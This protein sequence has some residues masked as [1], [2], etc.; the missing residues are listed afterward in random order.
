MRQLLD[1]DGA[2]KI[3]TR[4]Q[5]FSATPSRLHY[6]EEVII[7][8]SQFERVREFRAYLEP[9]DP[10]HGLGDEAMLR[11]LAREEV[12]LC[13]ELK[14]R[15]AAFRQEP[16]RRLFLATDNSDIVELVRERYGSG[17]VLM[18][19]KWYPTPGQSI[20][21]ARGC[22][23]RLEGAREALLD[24]YLLGSADWLVID[25]RSSF[26]YVARLLFRGSRARIRNVDPGRFL[27]RHVGHELATW[28]M[29]IEERWLRLV[30]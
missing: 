28:R 17:R 30:S 23:D 15:I 8:W 12:E 18:T 20:H 21:Y 29:Q 4:W 16:Q 1:R 22:P 9:Q 6:N 13:P 19:P 2:H 25:E 26:G 7:F 5:K 3:A 10:F 27:P 11:K 24:I 14:D